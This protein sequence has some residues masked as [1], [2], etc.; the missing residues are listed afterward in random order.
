MI[1]TPAAVHLCM[2][3][4]LVQTPLVHPRHTWYSDRLCNVVSHM[5]DGTRTVWSS[6]VQSSFCDVCSTRR[7]VTFCAVHLGCANHLCG[8]AQAF[9]LRFKLENIKIS[10]ILGKKRAIFLPY[11]NFSQYSDIIILS[12]QKSE[13]I[14][15]LWYLNNVALLPSWHCHNES[16]LS[17]IASTLMN[18]N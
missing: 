3:C 8:S 17:F 1:Y 4:S 13:C 9:L 14:T 11:K 7:V 15:L 6:D 5:R 12:I 10:L 18:H 2:L 16:L